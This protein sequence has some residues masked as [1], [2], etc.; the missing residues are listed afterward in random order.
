MSY[1]NCFACPSE[2]Y[3][4]FDNYDPDLTSSED[5]MSLVC[6]S[7]SSKLTTSSVKSWTLNGTSEHERLRRSNCRILC[8]GLN[9]IQSMVKCDTR[10]SATAGQWPFNLTKARSPH[11]N[12]SGSF[13]FLTP[14]YES[15]DRC[16][17]STASSNT[18]NSVT[19]SGVV[20]TAVPNTTKQ[21]LRL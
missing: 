1:L 21:I 16:S 17:L 8:G 5:D 2:G 10:N 18:T 20:T 3:S 19:S 12:A 13:L 15:V 14:I 7:S 11:R 6:S 9:K 4:T